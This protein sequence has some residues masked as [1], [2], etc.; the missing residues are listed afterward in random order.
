MQLLVTHRF[1][2]WKVLS[3]AYSLCPT[4][5]HARVL[6]ADLS[7]SST[8]PTVIDGI[9]LQ[10]EDT[11]RS[12]MLHQIEVFDDLCMMRESQRVFE[13]AHEK[14]GD[15]FPYHVSPQ[16]SGVRLQQDFM[17]TKTTAVTVSDA[18]QTIYADDTSLPLPQGIEVTSATRDSSEKEREVATASFPWVSMVTTSR[19]VP[20][21]LTRG[22]TGSPQRLVVLPGDAVMTALVQARELL[23][24][25]QFS[26]ARPGQNLEDDP[27][28]VEEQLLPYCHEAVRLAVQLFLAPGLP[29]GWSIAGAIQDHEHASATTSASASAT[30]SVMLPA[31]ESTQVH[32]CCRYQVILE[33][34]SSPVSSHGASGRLA[35][36]IVKI[37]NTQIANRS[38]SHSSHVS[39]EPVPTTL[40]IGKEGPE[41]SVEACKDVATM[42][43]KLLPM[44]VLYLDTECNNCTVIQTKNRKETKIWLETY[45][46]ATHEE[47]LLF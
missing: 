15:D 37:L 43:Q 17:L 22:T 13:L 32:V 30:E 21:G 2:S 23:G 20:G 8:K 3:Q 27:T 42:F 24:P 28:V 7:A 44:L 26:R 19:S 6:L 46:K 36:A 10:Q 39:A 18:F 12:G 16:C 33:E 4:E 1:G 31:A 11:G 40:R 9:R 38:S 29:A 25:P 47:S 14:V 45:C 41:L 35:K 5:N 34:V